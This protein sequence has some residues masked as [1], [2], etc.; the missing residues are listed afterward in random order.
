MEPVVRGEI[1]RTKCF[2]SLRRTL[3]KEHKEEESID[4]SKT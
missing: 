1:E 2:A 3:L 4:V